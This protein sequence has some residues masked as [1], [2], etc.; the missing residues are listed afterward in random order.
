MYV[1]L[2]V[3]V[4]LCVSV[5]THL[6]LYLYI[7]MY[8]SCGLLY[9]IHKF[10]DPTNL[11]PASGR[12]CRHRHAKMYTHTLYNHIYTCSNKQLKPRAR[13][14]MCVS[15]RIFTRRETHNTPTTVNV[16]KSNTCGVCIQCVDLFRGTQIPFLRFCFEESCNIN[17]T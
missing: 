17:K 6:Y 7:F 3:C 12:G 14:L 9:F 16:N 15:S 11:M 8:K 5:Y 2:G 10:Y 13:A 1:G 4:S